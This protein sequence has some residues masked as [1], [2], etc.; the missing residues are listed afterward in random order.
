MCGK[1]ALGKPTQGQ[2]QKLDLTDANI[3][4]GG[5]SYNESRY[6]EERT[7]GY[8]MFGELD[9][10]TEIKLPANTLK[11]EQ[12]AFH[13]C[14]SL[15]S[16][17]I[18][19]STKE[20]TPSIGCLRLAHISVTEGNPAY[21]GIDGVVYSLNGEALVWFPEGMEKD[22]IRFSPTLKSIGEYAL[23]KCKVRSI[24][25]PASL[26]SIGKSA[27]YAAEIE[28]VVLPDGLQSI[29]LGIFQQCSK[30][31]SV[32]LGSAC[33]TLSDYCFD[34][35]TLRHLYVKAAIP[36]VCQ[37]GT[38]YGVVKIF[39]DCTLHVPKESLPIYRNHSTWKQFQHLAIIE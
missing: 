26:T 30:L 16:L 28:S 27:F 29:P 15:T 31:V 9:I 19:G 23:Q 8:G 21:I 20:L 2:L 14:I 39:T 17:S 7:I 4:A 10:L 6:T 3:V 38:F 1:D 35:C 11:I 18:P 33:E 12:D 32:T 25:L 34:G 13:N 22:E 5:L 37:S 36:P 24:V